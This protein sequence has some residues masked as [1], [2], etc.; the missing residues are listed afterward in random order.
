MARQRAPETGGSGGMSKRVG[1]LVFGVTVLLV[2]LVATVQM[3]LLPYLGG[4]T[5]LRALLDGL[6]QV[7]VQSVGT[8]ASSSA[9][10][11]GAALSSGNPDCLCEQGY[12]QGHG[13]CTV[14]SCD[15]KVVWLFNSDNFT[16]EL[17][18]H[19]VE[20]TPWPRS[21]M[22]ADLAHHLRVWT[23]DAARFWDSQTPNSTLPSTSSAE[24]YVK[25]PSGLGAWV[26]PL[27]DSFHKAPSRKKYDRLASAISAWRL[28]EAAAMLSD[29][30]HNGRE[31]AWAKTSRREERQAG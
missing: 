15:N 9:A 28:E 23:R 17:A 8:G 22:D 16:Y 12:R 18:R 4:E 25:D 21:L 2:A 24:R 31:I 26:K 11:L 6:A 30:H 13:S 14:S 29:A 7:K 10:Q 1:R 3:L 19:G 5:A 27:R 20:L